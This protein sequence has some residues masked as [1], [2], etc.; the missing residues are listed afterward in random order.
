M[1]GQ[2]STQE[3]TDGEAEHGCASGGAGADVQIA[4]VSELATL[5]VGLRWINR[6]ASWCESTGSWRGWR[7]PLRGPVRAR[8]DQPHTQAEALH[9]FGLV[10]GPAGNC[11]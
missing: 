7:R 9:D 5:E 4:A 3:A 8:E 6:C 10:S 11:G 2:C 1:P